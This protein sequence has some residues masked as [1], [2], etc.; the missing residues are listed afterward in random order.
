M[1]LAKEEGRT[2]AGMGTRGR[3]LLRRK[4]PGPT[5]Q[6]LSFPPKRSLLPISWSRVQG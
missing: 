6:A 5:F 4:E 2:Q 1:G 3:V